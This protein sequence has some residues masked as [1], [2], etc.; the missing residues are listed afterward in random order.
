MQTPRILITR[1]EPGA[2]RTAE[3]LREAGYEPAVLPLTRIERLAFELPEGP[4]GGIVVTSAQAFGNADY[5]R[6]MTLPLIAVGET[7][8][9]A[10]RD[11][12]F[13]DIE[14]ATGSAESVA[15]LAKFTLKPGAR[16]LYLCGK[17][18]RP[19]LEELLAAAGFSVEAVETYN[20]G[21]IYHSKIEFG[22]MTG[23]K[24]FDAVI[25][26]SAVTA[27]LFSK[28]A[29]KPQFQNSLF[30]CFSQRIAG[31]AG[32]SGNRIAVTDEATEDSLMSLLKTHFKK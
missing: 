8:A 30:V 28:F 7:T 19:E 23:D 6:L 10:A 25:L 15:G 14:A 17:V 21:P 20:A 32:S 12:G 18:R 24:P 4:F 2:S 27:E 16:I 29:G 13:A 11:A 1:P 22:R 5:S 9:K 26:M 3:R 31:A